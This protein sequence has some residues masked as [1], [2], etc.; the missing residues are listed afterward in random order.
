MGSQKSCGRRH[1]LCPLA[2]RSILVPGPTGRSATTGGGGSCGLCL[3]ETEELDASGTA[4]L[5]KD[6]L[7]TVKVSLQIFVARTPRV[8]LRNAVVEFGQRLRR[9]RCHVAAQCLMHELNL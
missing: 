9:C 8:G 4:R 2:A 7:D 5:G 3:P 6:F 1:I